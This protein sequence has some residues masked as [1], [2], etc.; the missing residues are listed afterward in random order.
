MRRVLTRRGALLGG[1]ALLAGCETIDDILGEKR[2]RFDGERRSVVDVPERRLS[3]DDAAQGTAVTLPPSAP[4]ADWPQIGGDA[5][6][7]GGHPAFGPSLSQAWRSSFGTGSAYRRR[8]VTGPVASGGMVFA[9]DASGD[10]TAIDATNGGRRW[11]RDIGRENE[12]SPP[13]GAGAAAAGETLYV[14]TGLAELIALNIADGAVRWRVDLPAPARGAPSIAD[15]RVYVPT[16][17]S[18]LVCLAADDGK[19]IWSHRASATTTIPLGLG[20]PAIEGETVVAGFPSGELFA[21]RVTDGRVLWTES[22]AAAG[23]GALSD[24]AGVRASPVISGGRVIAVGVGGL[25]VCVDLRSG[26]RLWEQESGGT[27]SPWIAGEWVFLTNDVGQVA[28]IGRDSGQVRWV[29]SL[30]P[31]PRGNRRPDRIQ[32]SSPVLAGGRLLVGTGREEI[33]SIDPATGTVQGRTSLSGGVTL[34]PIVVGNTLIVA[35]DAAD[36]V[37]FSGG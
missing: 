30:R 34:Q 22:L 10:M 37:A 18:Q 13:L 11:R 29:T 4:R 15:G 19:R 32:L 35:T 31:E 8:I 1:A 28:A 16:V 7:S 26:R 33:V 17:A 6:H 21:M 20:T 36:L 25:T 23:T 14:A 2:Q 9:A 24:I 5:A 3:A 27:E 12:S